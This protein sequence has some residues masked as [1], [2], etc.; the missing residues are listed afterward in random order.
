LLPRE[1]E[2]VWN[3]LKEQSSLAGFVLI[4]GTALA[5][6][7]K[8]RISEDLDLA[9]LEQLLPKG[10]IEALLK[11]GTNAGF[12]IER[13]DAPAAVEEF[14]LGGLDLHDYQQDFIVNAKVKLSLFTA[15]PP[16][17]KVLTERAEKTPRVA[18]LQ[19]LFK[20]KALVSAL[21]SKTRDWLD[22]YLL[23]RDHGFRIEDF[24]NAFQETGDGLQMDLALTRLCTGVP[25]RRDEG[26]F[27]L[28][29]QAP[30]LDEIRD[31]FRARREELE[32]VLARNAAGQVVQN[33]RD[34]THK[35]DG[36]ESAKLN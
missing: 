23:M 16:L 4:G 22:L 3:F 27:H 8:H 11:T 26:Y 13:N 5:M 30:S 14:T 34:T 18:T 31:F 17:S 6:R 19:E 1:T 21:R 28:L 32:V 10:R 20:S 36:G 35:T 29:S 24:R 25:E 9:C 12:Q 7:I 15:D 2:E 33:R